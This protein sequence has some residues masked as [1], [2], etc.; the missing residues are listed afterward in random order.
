MNQRVASVAIGS[1]SDR[2]APERL[3]THPLRESNGADEE[4][5]ERPPPA[6]GASIPPGPLWY[7]VKPLDLFMITGSSLMGCMC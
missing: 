1:S 6:C 2:V 7:A 5:G 3:Y 4:A